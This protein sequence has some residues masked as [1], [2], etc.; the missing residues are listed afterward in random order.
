MVDLDGGV[1]PVDLFVVA[2]DV[3]ELRQ[4]EQSTYREYT[5]SDAAVDRSFELSCESLASLST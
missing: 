3:V 1:E 5:I 2:G 4:I